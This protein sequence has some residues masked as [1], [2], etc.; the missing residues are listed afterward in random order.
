MG[1]IRFI[2]DKELNLKGVEHSDGTIFISGDEAKGNR[3]NE[4]L[5]Y[6]VWQSEKKANFA[7]TLLLR[8]G[9]DGYGKLKLF[10]L[11]KS[12]RKINPFDVMIQTLIA[13]YYYFRFSNNKLALRILKDTK[14]E[15]LKQYEDV[16]LNMANV[17]CSLR[18]YSRAFDYYIRSYEVCLFLGRNI[19]TDR[20][21]NPLES[22]I[23][24]CNKEI[25]NKKL[26]KKL[27]RKLLL[28][29]KNKDDYKYIKQY[30]Q[31]QHVMK[32]Q[33]LKK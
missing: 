17:Y 27:Y 11:L 6:G 23:D 22:I 25:R 19:C 26:A 18:Q 33:I 9:V 10:K 28:R 32:K 3:I 2:Y 29:I 1:R 7:A 8:I 16:L 13:D 5:K 14:I 21:H 30:I 12:L 15:C 20:R 4:K 24:M 31:K